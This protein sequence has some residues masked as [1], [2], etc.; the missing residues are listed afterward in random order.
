MFNL[1]ELIRI[2]NLFFSSKNALYKK[3]QISSFVV[4]SLHIKT[5]CAFGKLPVKILKHFIVSISGFL[6]GYG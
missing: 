2:Y 6:V 1:S 3:E 4:E 5:F